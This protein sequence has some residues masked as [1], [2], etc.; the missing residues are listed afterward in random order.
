MK[1]KKVENVEEPNY[2]TNTKRQNK[3]LKLI[4]EHKII[5]ITIVI[6]LLLIGIGTGIYVYLY[7][8]AVDGLMPD[9]Y[10]T[11]TILSE[12]AR[13]EKYAGDIVS[14]P[15]VKQL[16][17]AI[18]VCNKNEIYPEDIEIFIYDENSKSFINVYDDSLYP[19]LKTPDEESSLNLVTPVPGTAKEKDITSL[20]ADRKKYTVEMAEYD[21]TY[22]YLKKITIKE[23]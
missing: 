3:F 20:I 8:S 1:I 23:H 21:D 19:D 14:G 7:Q 12:N 16:L 22:G 2:D 9:Y 11:E 17:R 6:T 4:F 10:G 18:N 5:T 13:F 15:E